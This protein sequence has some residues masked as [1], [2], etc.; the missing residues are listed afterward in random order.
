MV[1]YHFLKI[2]SSK[3]SRILRPLYL[4]GLILYY[5]PRSNNDDSTDVSLSQAYFYATG[6]VLTTLL[7]LF[8]F[9][10]MQLLYFETSM[11][12]KVA[13]T[14][15]IYEKILRMSVCTITDGINGQAV[16]LISNDVATF[17]YATCFLQEL[18]VGP[19]EA[20]VMGYFIYRE[21][22]CSGLF[23]IAVILAFIPLQGKR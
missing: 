10:P 11:K 1:I 22:Q 19:V 20:V 13:C 16:N 3:S 15:L 14:S 17:D 4:G 18:W 9:H 21:I 7:P 12:I 2:Y 5:T 8:L 6:I 23:G